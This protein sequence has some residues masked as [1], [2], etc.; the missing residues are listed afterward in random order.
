MSDELNNPPANGSESSPV[1][2]PAAV[3]PPEIEARLSAVL[4]EVESLKSQR[5]Q[6]QQL[7]QTYQAELGRARQQA[8]KH[9]EVESKFDDETR[10]FVTT[11]AE[12]EAARIV[13]QTVG[14]LSLQADVQQKLGESPELVKRT[15]A[16]MSQLKQSPYYSNLSDEILLSFATERA[17][18][19]FY[20]EQADRANA[21]HQKKQQEEIRQREASGASLPSTTRQPWQPTADDPDADVKY[22]EQQPE[23]QEMFRKLMRAEPFSETE[24]QFA[25][26]R[27]KVKAKDAY[28][29]LAIRAVRKGVQV[30]SQ[31][32]AGIAALGGTA[33]TERRGS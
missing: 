9:E 31:T 23:S 13:N 24:V 26:G 1:T 5:S 16:E 4:A 15:Q 12:R 22:W 3:V 6:D 2:T 29:Q 30:S 21:E 19:S 25:P 32:A 11:V 20:K 10:R 33:I 27:P 18:S 14:K 28:R 17:R 7:L 8:P